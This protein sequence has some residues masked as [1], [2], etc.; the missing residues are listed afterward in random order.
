M[1]IAIWIFEFFGVLTNLSLRQFA[2]F[3]KL[4][5]LVPKNELTWRTVPHRI[6]WKYGAN[7][8]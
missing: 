7:T 4:L 1:I 3:F 6:L 5:N 2:I 8:A